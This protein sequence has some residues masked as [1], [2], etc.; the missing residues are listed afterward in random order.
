M[1]IKPSV[2]DRCL[3][4]STSESATR[5]FDLQLYNYGFGPKKYE[6]II[7][8]TSVSPHFPDDIIVACGTGQT[9]SLS[10]LFF[11]FKIK[12][13]TVVFLNLSSS[14]WARKKITVNELSKVFLHNLQSQYSLMWI[15]H[16][17]LIDL[18]QIMLYI[19][20]N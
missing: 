9:L 4:H 3:W 14:A 5:R 18:I 7:P 12:L 15:I 13:F 6:R 2:E 16:A 17:L 19:M 11:A 8:N 10:D 1:K 20:I